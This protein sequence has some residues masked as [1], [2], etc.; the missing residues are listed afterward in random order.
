[1]MTKKNM[2]YSM[3]Q[4]LLLLLW[5]L[6][7]YIGTANWEMMT[8][9]NMLYSMEQFIYVIDVTTA[10]WVMMT[11]KNMV[12]SMEQEIKVGRKAEWHCFISCV[13]FNGHIYYYLIPHE[14][15]APP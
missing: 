3:E 10:N 6:D 1:M 7:I 4:M 14:R 9:K 11:N 5:V 15:N 12:Y 8:N 2:W 13:L